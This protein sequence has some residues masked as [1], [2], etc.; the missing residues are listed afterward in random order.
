MK[1]MIRVDYDVSTGEAVVRFPDAFSALPKE[2]QLEI[3]QQT[4]ERMESLVASLQAIIARSSAG[5][6]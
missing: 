4:L 2:Q 3:A 5:N 6:P 1:T